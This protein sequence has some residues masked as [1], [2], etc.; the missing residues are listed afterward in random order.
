M[1]TPCKTPEDAGLAG[2]GV[3]D[4]GPEMAERPHEVAEGLHVAERRDRTHK[5]GQLDDLHPRIHRGE[6]L[7]PRL[8]AV[9]KHDGVPGAH[10]LV[11]GD[12]GVF[13]RAAVYEARDD[14]CNP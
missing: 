8:S 13:I 6:D 2:M 4:V 5:A 3:N 12:D 9:D 10:G 14:M 1:C 11:A 7:R